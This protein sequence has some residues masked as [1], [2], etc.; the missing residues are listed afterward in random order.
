MKPTVSD[1]RI[2]RESGSFTLRTSGSSVTKSASETTAVP[3]VSVL[4]SVVLPAFV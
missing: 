2:W 3:P 4:N 1:S